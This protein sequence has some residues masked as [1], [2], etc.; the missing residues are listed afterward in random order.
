MTTISKREQDGR[1]FT[2]NQIS[3]FRCK[4]CKGIAVRDRGRVRI[5]HNAGCPILLR[6]SLTYPA[7]IETLAKYR[8]IE[9][10]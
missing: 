3:G 7:F 6:L 5:A 9:S 2:Y 10:S 1:N 8:L 4:G